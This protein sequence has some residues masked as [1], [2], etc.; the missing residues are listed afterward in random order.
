MSIGS[1]PPNEFFELGETQ[2]SV[3]GIICLLGFDSVRFHWALAKGVGSSRVFS[4][5]EYLEALVESTRFI[6]RSILARAVIAALW[7]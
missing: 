5:A 4:L 6:R 2:L 1:E 3:S 7:L